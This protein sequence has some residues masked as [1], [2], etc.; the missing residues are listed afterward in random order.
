[1]R[2]S[3]NVLKRYFAIKTSSKIL[4]H[5]FFHFFS[6]IKNKKWNSHGGH[7]IIMTLSQQNFFLS[8]A[9][10]NQLKVKPVLQELQMFTKILIKLRFIIGVSQAIKLCFQCRPQS[11]LGIPV[12]ISTVYLSGT[13]GPPSW[14]GSLSQ[15]VLEFIVPRLT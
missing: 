15:K 11:F 1:M 13:K 4:Y 10:I 14:L 5:C 12:H 8:M 6:D 7:T 3:Y 2:L 9:F